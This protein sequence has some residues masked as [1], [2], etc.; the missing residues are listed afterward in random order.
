MRN[1]LLLALA[2][3]AFGAA[4][5]LALPVMPADE[6]F[7][8]VVRCYGADGPGAAGNTRETSAP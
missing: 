1:S 4:L 8:E 5:R 7:R 6:S 2:I 3:G